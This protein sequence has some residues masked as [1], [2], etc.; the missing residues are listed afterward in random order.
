MSPNVDFH[1]ATEI[2]ALDF[3]V[4]VLFLLSSGVKNGPQRCAHSLAK[5]KKDEVMQPL[6]L[7]RSEREKR[8]YSILSSPPASF[9][10]NYLTLSWPI[11]ISRL[12]TNNNAPKNCCTCA[13]KQ[14]RSW[15]KICWC[16]GPRI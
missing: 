8:Y 3:H 13:D 4:F 15:C 11:G 2:S 1:T 7:V 9:Y 14:G 16:A 5:V 6:F 10:L 12:P